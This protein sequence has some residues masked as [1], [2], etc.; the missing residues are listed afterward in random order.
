[1]GE[2]D[3][4]GKPRRA[5]L[6]AAGIREAVLSGAYVPGQ[7]LVEADLCQQYQVGRSVVRAALHEL[8]NDGTVELQWH[9]GA[10]VRQVGLDEAIEIVEVRMLV[11]GLVAAKAAERARPEDIT[12]L[13]WNAA[14]M[15]KAVAQLDAA[16]YTQLNGQCHALIQQIAGHTTAGGVLDRLRA[17]GVRDHLHSTMRPGR[18]TAS[19]REHVKIIE[20][21]AAKDSAAAQAAMHE[22]LDE[23][24]RYL[25]T[26]RES[27]AQTVGEGES[28]EPASQS[29]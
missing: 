22:H 1:M 28:A 15:R 18:T 23:V 11:E 13:R 6:V 7:R 21:V 27:E 17:Q 3:T 25:R 10:R 12:R 29:S 9:R 4:E 19:L 16:S 2:P 20:A 14:A 5:P 26:R 24:L 8:A